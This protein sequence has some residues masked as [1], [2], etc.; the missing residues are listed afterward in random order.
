MMTLR[1]G[2]RAYL[3]ILLLSTPTISGLAQTWPICADGLTP[4]SAWHWGTL[5]NGLRYVIRKNTQPAGHISFRF[6]VQVGFA[7]ETKAERG[8]AHFVEHMAF[9]GTKHFPGESLVM[10]LRKHGLEIGPEVNAFTLLSHTIY[11]LDAP[12]TTPADLER[13]FTVLRDFADGMKFDKKQ[14]Q[15][16]RGV[17]ASETRDRQSPG[18]RAEIARRRFLY[19]LSALSNPP[20]GD[21]EHTDAKSLRQFYAKWYRPERMILVVVGDAEVAQLETLVRRHFAT[22]HA[23]TTQAPRFNAGFIGNPVSYT[24]TVVHD[25]K[26][27]G[28]KVEITSVLP[29]EAA[30]SLAERRCWLARNHLIYMLNVRLGEVLRNK[31]GRLLQLGVLSSISTPYSIET[32]ISFEAPSAEWKLGMITLGQELQRSFEY[33]FTGD[34]IREARTV[35]LTAYEQQVKTSSTSKSPDLAG[36]VMQQILWGFV[37]TSPEDQL[38]LTREW[39]PQIDALEINRAWRSLWQAQ[40]ALMFAYGFFPAPD[41]PALLDDAFTESQRR[42]ITPPTV[43]REPSFAYTDFGPPGKIA[44]REYVPE[45]DMHLVEFENGVRANLKRTT[46]AAA[47]VHLNAHLGRGML[48]EP[49]GQPG[50]GA[51][52]TGTFLNGALGR[53]QPEELRRIMAASVLSMSFSSQ[54]NCFA[55]NGETTTASLEKLLCLM[56]AYLVDPGWNQEAIAMASTQ[57]SNY[58]HDLNYTPEGVI[59]LNVF[60]TLSDNDARYSIP[61]ADQVKTRTVDELKQ[62]LTPQLRSAPLEIGLVGDFDPEQ[63]VDLLSRTLGALPTRVSTAEEVRPVTLA[64]RGTPHQYSFQGE[65]NRAGI[66]AVWPLDNSASIRVTRQAEMLCAVFGERLRQRVREDLGAAYAPAV[67]FWK[68]EASPQSGYVT[69]YL[70]VKPNEVQRL[71][72]L[73]I[74]IADTLSREGATADEFTQ[75]REP[76]LARSL[77][78]QKGNAYWVSHVIAKVQSLPEVRQWPLTRISDFQ[79]M[80][81]T[82]LNNLA[83]EVLPGPHA[84]IFS[85]Q[86]QLK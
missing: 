63:A 9:N 4:D 67:S 21:P 7:H 54:E 29:Y 35:M 16:E 64:K 73:L 12:S 34:E 51:L 22:L 52:A 17:I 74:E 19:P 62:W 75:A 39:L 6:A 60:R 66:E 25:P 2:I 41:G 48:T 30:D 61:T 59:G 18:S 28:L 15:R 8:Y 83:R 72:K 43:K 37:S 78:D 81:L 56:G 49:A 53:H 24:S 23:S 27:N 55:F 11:N 45:L 10:E 58:Y 44:R 57:M 5:D 86:P 42:P 80:T 79:T 32:V 26:V 68:S 47:T 70:T 65:A 33:T 3:R 77:A 50:L 82:D 31:P 40:R 1:N 13:W 85:A 76:I 38:R 20:D 71:T 36:N 69:A 46:F 14:V 84:I